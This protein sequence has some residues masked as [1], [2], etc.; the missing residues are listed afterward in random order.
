MR[1]EEKKQAFE[2]KNEMVR[3]TAYGALGI[4]FEFIGFLLFPALVGYIVEHYFLSP[5]SAWKSLC[6]PIGMGIGFFGGL[7][8]VYRRTK[9]L[10]DQMKNTQIKTPRQP[11]EKIINDF[12]SLNK[13]L[14]DL[15]K[16]KKKN[17][18]S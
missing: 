12:D 11:P 10:T 2:D 17:E 9:A 14:D 8:M 3:Q 4:G 5:D 13:K 1:E 7:W 6:L 16:E 18:G 15:I